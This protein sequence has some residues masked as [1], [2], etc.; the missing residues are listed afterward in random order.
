MH[1]LSL[2]GLTGLKVTHHDAPYDDTE[3]SKE[4]CLLSNFYPQEA[5]KR[6]SLTVQRK[7]M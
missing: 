6:H 7:E 2:T 3:R 5:R 4:V 1:F